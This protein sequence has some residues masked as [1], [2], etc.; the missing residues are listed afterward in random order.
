V[1]GTLPLLWF[2][3]GLEPVALASGAGAILAVLWVT[4][5][6]MQGRLRL[7]HAI[8]LESLVLGVLLAIGSAAAAT[9]VIE[10]DPQVQRAVERARA[11]YLHHQPFDRM[12]V[13]VLLRDATGTWRRGSVEGHIPAYPAS[14]VKLAF[15]VGA[16][17]WCREQ[18]L[19]PEC[20]DEFVRP[21]IVESDNVA[22]GVVVDRI[23]GAPNAAVA[24]TDVDAW[25]ERRRYTERVLDA[26]GLL[27]PQRLL[28]KTYP[29]NSGEEPRDLERLAWQQRGRNA[30]TP[31]LTAQ[32]LL[33]I[34]SGAIEPQATGYMRALLRR[35]RYSAHSGLGGGLPPGTDHENKPGTAFD[36]LQDVVHARLPDG[37]QLVIAAF[38]NGWD[39]QE[40]APWD[41][42]RL[43][44]FTVR[45][46]AELGGGDRSSRSRIVESTHRDGTTRFRWRNGEAGRYELSVW[47]DANRGNTP[48]ARARLQPAGASA[49][50]ELDE[51]TW[52]HRWI[53]L[54]DFDLPRG[55]NEVVIEPL[56]PGT[57]SDAR[58]RITPWPRDP[59]S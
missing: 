40:P 45:L 2:A 32:L 12:Q 41:I 31:D 23:T 28:T 8:A 36:T 19:A 39:Q 7:R 57:L 25:M 21:M 54:G 17:H 50:L 18:G 5:A 9:P 53:R 10:D 47:Y 1:L 46:L 33:H 11:A 26:A 24:G 4:G 35:P 56:A 43:N 59:A 38:T 37:R 44:D 27:G 3:P 30:M 42:A 6:V 52:G 51:S 55:V 58:L 14:V 49:E 22:T 48:R 13:S 29:S 15:L 20:L 16:V 34:V